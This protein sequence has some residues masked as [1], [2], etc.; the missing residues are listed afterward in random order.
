MLA[1]FRCLRLCHFRGSEN[2]S[3]GR[4]LS[5]HAL[6]ALPHLSKLVLCMGTFT[7]VDA[8]QHLTC[9]RL[10]RAHCSCTA[11]CAFAA[12]LTNL[13][14]QYSQLKNFHKEGL[15]TLS[16]LRHLV[17]TDASISAPATDDDDKQVECDVF[18]AMSALTKL[19]VLRLAGYDGGCE[20][21]CH[22]LAQLKDLHVLSI[23]YT[24]LLLHLP[25]AVSTLG[26]LSVLILDTGSEGQVVCNFE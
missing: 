16:G 6:Q 4:E 3:A 14:I 1:K 8:A 10:W 7:H 23:N 17:L 12:S 21:H 15:A 13:A 22:W 19:T 24:A 11:P 25:E 20:M 18:T 2:V 9:L 26:K 5:L